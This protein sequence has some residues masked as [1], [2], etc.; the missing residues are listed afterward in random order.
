MGN[1]YALDLNSTEE[2]YSDDT[3]CSVNIEKPK[4]A[5]F[6]FLD[7]NDNGIMDDRIISRISGITVSLYEKGQKKALSSV[8]TNINGYYEFEAEPEKSEC[9]QFN[10]N[11]T[12]ASF[13]SAVISPASIA[14]LILVNVG[15][16]G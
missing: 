9:G 4:I 12:D 1:A 11:G 6:V 15:L 16:V 14:S 5:G 7:K 3:L 8:T 2:D 13:Q 10:T